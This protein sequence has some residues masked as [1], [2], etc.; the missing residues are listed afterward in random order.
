M[1]Q[2]GR[3]RVIGELGHGAMGVVFR[4]LDPTIGR[5]VALKTIRLG[6]F[7]N[8]EQR[9]RQRDRLFREA[10]SAGIL[11]HPGIVTIFDVGEQ[12]GVAYIAMELVNGVTLEQMMAKPEA[13]DRERAI[14]MLGQTAEALDYAHRKGIIHR[15]IK[16]ANIMIVSET[17]HIKI[18]DFGIAKITTL[19]QLT[20]AGLMVGTPNY[21][22][23]EQVQGKTVT[24]RADQYSL[25]VIA[26]EMMT[27]EKP[28]VADHLPPLVYKIVMED[29]PPAA[30]LNR[31]LGQKIEAV[32]R[33]GLSKSPDD[34]YASCLELV[35]TLEEACAATPGWKTQARGATFNLPTVS[36][37]TAQHKPA[38]PPQPEAITLP[39]PR[40]RPEPPPEP[41]RRAVP[42]F[43]AVLFGLGLAGLVYY[44]R[45]P[46]APDIVPPPP[47]PPLVESP[48]PEKSA[49]IRQPEAVT[50]APAPAEPPKT[51]PPKTEPP[52]TEPSQV[53]PAKV[54]PE[55]P[56]AEAPRAAPPPSRPPRTSPTS[57]EVPIRSE[58]PRAQVMLD[59][60]PG[61]AC[62]TPCTLKA[63]TGVHNITVSR[64]GF[65]TVTRE[66]RVEPD[67]YEPPVVTM[68]SAMGVIM[69]QSQPDGASIF[70]NDKPV[71]QKTPAQLNLPPGH[72][73]IRVEK[74]DLKGAQTVEVRDQG[75]HHIAI[76]LT[77]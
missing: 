74:G 38:P 63:T 49:V 48:K 31:T 56:K 10:R 69:L 76:P 1:E 9:T 13:L 20:Q 6:D 12:D 19:D 15:D 66:I 33:R 54:E 18:T 23:P 44:A 17:G 46:I 60:L 67:M 2:L 32:L 28:F 53:E 16:P 75:F 8:A 29:P 41:K 59:G 37:E 73:T 52:K 11:S 27:G 64:P 39:P 77:Q 55:P 65:R 7:T 57:V 70:V 45:R 25:C 71:P 51:E 68:V 26:F 47:K 22:A 61:T 34:R 72:Y 36:T 58:P 3:Y 4:A 24:G 21:M 42:V 43:L 30:R 14:Q 50:P 5:E 40:P 35:E 62:N